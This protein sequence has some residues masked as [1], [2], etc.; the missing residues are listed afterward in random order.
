MKT[1]KKA[2]LLFASLALVLGAGLVG[3]SDTK[4]V[5][6]ANTLDVSISERANTLNWQNGYVQSGW[7]DQNNIFTFSQ[8]GDGNNGKYYSSDSS[9]RFYTGGKAIITSPSDY[10]LQS[11]TASLSNDSTQKWTI[12]STK[13]E[14][15]FAFTSSTRILSIS[16][17]Y[18]QLSLPTISIDGSV[19]TIDINT[20]G[21]FTVTTKNATKPIITWES[22]NPEVLE[23]ENGTYAAYKVGSATITASMTCDESPETKITTSVDI[24]VIDPNAHEITITGDLEVE[25][26][27][28]ATLV[29]SCSKEDDITWTCA[30]KTVATISNDGVVTGV[31]EGEATVTATCKNGTKA[32]YI[33]KV[34]KLVTQVNAS[35]VFSNKGYAN[36]Q[37]ITSAEIDS[38]TTISFDKATGNNDPKYYT[39]G[40]AVRVYAKNT[41]TIKLD[42]SNKKLTSISLTFA[43]GEDSNAITTDVG[44]FSSTTWTGV[45]QSVTFT[46]GGASGHRRIVAIDVI[47][48]DVVAKFIED[49]AALRAKGGENGICYFLTNNTRSELDDMI[50][51]YNKLSAEDKAIVDVASDGGTTIANT[52]EYVSAL[53]A[54]LDDKSSSGKSGVVITSN[55][56]YDKTSLIALF[57]ILGIVTISGYYI[58]EKKKF[59]K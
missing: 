42:D 56:S 27:K 26:S 58:I 53:L 48:E 59:S 10:S 23:V 45:A 24:E 47:Y 20:T 28:T 25:V 51:R 40:K 55:N 33:I 41:F 54:K 38:K 19:K 14:A 37:V 16:I 30:P 43:S 36:Q 21:E 18:E 2:S 1:I 34:N 49:W 13:K 8:S 12:D 9:W 6:A 32:T 15:S 29:A 44:T 31:S 50:T 57:A 35:I 11:V 7:K 39:T 22:S 5:K 4:E 46:V 52:I 3:N 17:A